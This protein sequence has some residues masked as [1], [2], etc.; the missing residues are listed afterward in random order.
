MRL[1]PLDATSAT[2]L[3]ANGIAMG[4][5]IRHPRCQGGLNTQRL[6]TYCSECMRGVDE[7]ASCN[8]SADIVVARPACSLRPV[9]AKGHVPSVAGAGAIR[10]RS[11][12]VDGDDRLPTTDATA[13]DD[14]QR[15]MVTAGDGRR[16]PMATLDGQ[17]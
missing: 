13:A 9:A 12:T 16:R 2:T 14:R 5:L 17:R 11:P 6:T 15:P 4:K 8:S 3:R 10:R 7:F 1:S